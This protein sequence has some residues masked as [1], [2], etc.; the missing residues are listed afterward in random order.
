MVVFVTHLEATFFKQPPNFVCLLLQGGGNAEY[1][2]CPESQMMP[3]PANLDFTQAAAIPEVWITAFQLLH[4]IGESEGLRTMVS[5][6][7]GG[8]GMGMTVAT[9]CLS[10]DHIGRGSTHC[11]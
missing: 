4:T 8:S 6:N 11:R 9:G 2:T 5:E 7:N 3:I 10:I 1:V